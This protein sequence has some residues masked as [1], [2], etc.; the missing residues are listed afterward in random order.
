MSIA[1][2][3]TLIFSILSLFL[4]ISSFSWNY[5][6]NKDQ[7]FL[8]VRELI[9][10]EFHRHEKNFLMERKK[11]QNVLEDLEELIISFFN[12]KNSLNAAFDVFI[13][14][15]LFLN[16]GLKKSIVLCENCASFYDCEALKLIISCYRDHFYGI[17]VLL[18]LSE[19]IKN[20]IIKNSNFNQ[21]NNF[22]TFSTISRIVI[23]EKIFLKYY[24]TLLK[25][26]KSF[27]EFK[28]LKSWKEKK[29]NFGIFFNERTK[30]ISESSKEEIRKYLELFKNVQNQDLINVF[31]K[32][33]F[34]KDFVLSY[35]GSIEI[36]KLQFQ[37]TK[38]IF[39][40]FSTFE[41][42]QKSFVIKHKNRIR[43]TVTRCHYCCFEGFGF[44]EI[45]KMQQ[46]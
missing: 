16:K 29:F 15:V 32:D 8:K 45:F 35:F 3:L 26:K 13:N 40:Q 9:I 21:Q 37:N 31:Y 33:D 1:N 17:N 19:A 36:L 11:T 38:N 30:K 28:R 23:L 18:N 39:D 43:M 5:F 22:Q 12:K 41:P 24:I 25:D 7:H 20:E 2:I 44:H 4:A 34:I 10:K 46:K 6:W 27:K 42:L 14:N